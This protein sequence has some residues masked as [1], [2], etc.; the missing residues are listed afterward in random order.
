MLNLQKGETLYGLT[1]TGKYKVWTILV[2]DSTIKIAHGLEN[3][4]LTVSERTITQGKCIGKSN[5]RTPQQQAVLEATSRYNKQID[6]GYRK[7][8]QDLAFLPVRPMLAQSYTENLSRIKE[9][10]IYIVQPKLNGVRCLVQRHGRSLSFTSRQGKDYTPIL[11][12]HK[13]LV[14]ELLKVMPD[15]AIW[16]GEI[17]KHGAPLQDITSWVKEYQE[18]TDTLQYWVYDTISTKL[19]YERIADCTQQINKQKFLKFVVSCPLDYADSSTK[20]KEAHN[21]FISEGFEGLMLRD[22]SGTYAQGQRS[23]KLLKFK[24]FRDREYKIVGATNDVN[25]CVIWTCEHEGSKFNVVPTGSLAYRQQ[26]WKDAP[27]YIGSMLTVRFSDLSKKGIPIG[28]PVG[29]VIRD[30]E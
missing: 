15:G 21:K 16:D 9:G 29:V 13:Q 14:A 17:Y 20:I 10:T 25:G 30:Y 2:E 18:G 5:E 12:K 3:G 23:N 26:L 6:K 1:A 7:D 4:T 11:S 22:Y 24:N 28:N 8:K 19:Q 27:K